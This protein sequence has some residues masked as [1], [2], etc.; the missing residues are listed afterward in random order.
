MIVSSTNVLCL[1]IDIDNTLISPSMSGGDFFV[2]SGE[3]RSVDLRYVFY[4]GAVQNGKVMGT[5]WYTLLDGLMRL[6]AKYNVQLD[7]HLICSKTERV[8]DR[9]VDAAVVLFYPFLAVRFSNFSNIHDFYLPHHYFFRSYSNRGNTNYLT[10]NSLM[11]QE[12][13]TFTYF[14][15][16]LYTNLLPKIHMVCNNE[17]APHATEDDLNTF[18]EYSLS[19]QKLVR[20][21]KAQA[22]QFIAQEIKKSGK[23]LIGMILVDDRPD[24]NK[25]DVEQCGYKFVSAENI[26][27]IDNYCFGVFYKIKQAVNVICCGSSTLCDKYQQCA[28]CPESPKCMTC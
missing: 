17:R 5:S 11:Y 21:S 12:R 18:D 16:L 14:S 22:M 3:P 23:N 1:C 10:V 27:N 20:T 24:P 7:V 6:C 13:M 4:N 28:T 26:F 8:P 19:Q 9:V 15:S 25:A 2:V